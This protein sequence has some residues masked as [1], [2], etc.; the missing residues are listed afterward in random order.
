[1]SEWRQAS[2]TPE[3]GSIVLA[4][5]IAKNGGFFSDAMFDGGEWLL[6]H[7]ETDAYCV[8]FEP[9]HWMPMPAPPITNPDSS[10]TPPE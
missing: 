6:F 1:M 7:P 5:G 9:S 3:S 4:Y 2:D 8:E 10:P